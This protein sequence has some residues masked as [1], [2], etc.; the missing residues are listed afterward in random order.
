[1][2]GKVS[3]RYGQE[4]KIK[5]TFTFG[6]QS[7]HLFTYSFPAVAEAVVNIGPPVTWDKNH[8]VVRG[9]LRAFYWNDREQLSREE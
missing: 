2:S 6:N 7:M 8:S 5:T 3:M 4:Y 9:R 1:M